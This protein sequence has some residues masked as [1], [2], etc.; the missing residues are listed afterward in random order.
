MEKVPQEKGCVGF[1]PPPDGW[2]IFD[3][4]DQA[5]ADAGIGLCYIRV[6]PRPPAMRALFPKPP[7]VGARVE[8]APC[9]G[10]RERA[11]PFGQLRPELARDQYPAQ[12][13]AL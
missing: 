3:R 13:F 6:P 7:P 10:R 5:R 8:V 12:R 1:R 2:R 9:G 4:R 11:K